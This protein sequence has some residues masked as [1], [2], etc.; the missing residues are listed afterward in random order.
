MRILAKATSIVGGTV[1]ALRRKD[2]PKEQA[3]GSKPMIPPAKNQGIMTLKMPVA[4]GWKDGRL[5]LCADAQ[6][7]G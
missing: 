2:S 1:A 7:H 6:D 3:M 5:P 4:E